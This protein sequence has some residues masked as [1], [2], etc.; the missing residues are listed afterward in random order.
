[1]LA[2]D[3]LLP[4]GLLENE[5]RSLQIGSIQSAITARRRH[6]LDTTASVL[7]Q[8]K[9]LEYSAEDAVAEFKNTLLDV[10]NCESERKQTRIFDLQAIIKQGDANGSAALSVV[11]MDDCIHDRFADRNQRKCSVIGSLH[12][13][14]DCFTGHVLPQECDHLFGGSRKVSTHFC[15]IEYPAPVVAAESACLNPCIRIVA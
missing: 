4:R 11:C 9:F 10:F 13:A 1:M 2:H 12:G 7:D 8:P 14:Y 3:G 6:A 5:S 15:G